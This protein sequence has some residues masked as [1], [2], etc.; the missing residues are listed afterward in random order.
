MSV[1][2]TFTCV[3]CLSENVTKT[4]L[5]RCYTNHELYFD[6]EESVKCPTCQEDLTRKDFC[7]HFKKSHSKD[8][9]EAYCCIC[10]EY[11]EDPA[12]MKKHFL[13]KHHTHKN[14]LTSRG[15]QVIRLKSDWV[16]NVFEVQ[17]D[18]TTTKMDINQILHE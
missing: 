8:G 1:R 10:L 4:A 11:F 9:R 6:I 5:D 17:A 16:R 3:I 13:K 14:R 12:P 2:K 7:T 18:G 15:G